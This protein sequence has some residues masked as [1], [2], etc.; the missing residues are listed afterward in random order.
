MRT[1]LHIRPCRRSDAREFVRLHHSHHKG[2]TQ[3]ADVF[4]LSAF[5]GSER[6][7]LL[8]L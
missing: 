7:W 3:A 5:V 6:A 8:R 4:R 2:K 1:A